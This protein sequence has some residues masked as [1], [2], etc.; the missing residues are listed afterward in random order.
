MHTKNCGLLNDDSHCPHGGSVDDDDL[1]SCHSF[2]HVSKCHGASSG[3]C[4]H[5]VPMASKMHYH[6]TNV[7]LDPLTL[8]ASGPSLA[9]DDF[10]NFV[11]THT[12]P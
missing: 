10:Q 3:C 4:I 5:L 6:Q 1:L 7:A 11:S 9:R 12:A 2:C 8:L